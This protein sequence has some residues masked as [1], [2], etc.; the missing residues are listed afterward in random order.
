MMDWQTIQDTLREWVARATGLPT[1]W[2]GE[3]VENIHTPH[4]ELQVGSSAG[5]GVDETRYTYDATQPNG[6]ELVRTQCGNRLF[7]LSCRA[8]TR[9][10]TPVGAARF[11]L[12]KVRTALQ[13]RSSLETF[14]ASNLAVVGH[15][16][17]I[18]LDA[19]FQDRQQSE[20]QLDIRFSTVVNETD[21]ADQG[22]WIESTLVSS[23]IKNVDG[24]S[25]PAGL[26]FDEEEIP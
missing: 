9:D 26:Q 17:L 2:F 1:Y 23:D 18:N 22:Q 13:K 25:L 10:Q 24:S 7:M 3:D 20:A 21:P 15:E 19:I 14:R 16:P 8:R 12:E 11:Y 6:Q 5:L 4:C